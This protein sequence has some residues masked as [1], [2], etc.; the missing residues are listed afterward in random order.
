MNSERLISVNDNE[1]LQSQAIDLLRFPLAIA[2]IFIHMNPAVTPILTAEF[3]LLSGHG[4]LNIIQIALSRVLS[5]VAVP[6]FFLISGFLF[7]NN[8]REWNWD[9]Y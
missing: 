8:F 5:S 2:V 1:A 6:C 7:F 9:R 3:P 4:I